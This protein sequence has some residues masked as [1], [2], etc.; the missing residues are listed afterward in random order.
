MRKHIDFNTMPPILGYNKTLLIDEGDV[1]LYVKETNDPLLAVRDYGQG[2]VLT[3]T[4]DPAPHWGC[5][6]IFWERY[7]DFWLRCLDHLLKK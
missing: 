6:F 5:N 7:N 1:L 2:R 3:Y 4:S